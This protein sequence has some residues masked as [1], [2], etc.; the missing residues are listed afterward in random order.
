MDCQ[1][2]AANNI[3]MAVKQYVKKKKRKENTYCLVCKKK[4]NNAKIRA[5]TLV[6]KIATERSLWTVFASRKSTFSKPKI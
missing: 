5:V 6:N 1:K 2:N 3:K 4:T